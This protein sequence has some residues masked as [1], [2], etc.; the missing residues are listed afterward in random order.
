M[1]LQKFQELPDAPQKGRMFIYAGNDED[2]RI[3]LVESDDQCCWMY[4]TD[5]N[6][7][8]PQVGV[9][10]YNIVPSPSFEE[11][12]ERHE[13][14]FQPPLPS[15]YATSEAVQPPHTMDDF[16]VAWSETH[17]A[18]VVFIK[19]EEWALI[20]I[21]ESI[22]YTRAIASPSPYGHPWDQGAYLGH[23][24]EIELKI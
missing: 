12:I 17:E 3:L 11:S 13:Q 14:G 16:Q 20:E 1:A 23:F 22:A 8:V 4:L 5:E 18:V 19:G 9:L 24:A 21:E 10:L 2:D 15:E 7:D 6:G